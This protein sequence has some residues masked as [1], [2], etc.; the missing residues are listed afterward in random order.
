[1]IRIGLNSHAK[2]PWQ[3]VVRLTS[4][5]DG[6]AHHLPEV[7]GTEAVLVVEA[8]T[9]A[10]LLVEEAVTGVGQAV[11]VTGAGQAVDLR[12]GVPAGRVAAIVIG[13]VMAATGAALDVLDDPHRTHLFARRRP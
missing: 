11:A 12:R 10:A 6:H 1:M 13:A 8:A 5:R 2:R 7:A 4:S 3:S 9:E